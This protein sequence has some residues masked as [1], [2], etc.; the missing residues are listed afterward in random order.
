M[1][2]LQSYRKWFY[3][4]AVYNAVWGAAVVLFPSLIFRTL[5]M[6]LPNYPALMQCIGMLVGVYAIGYWMVGS[7]PERYGP[8][9]YVGLAGKILGPLGYLWA[10]HS[11]ALPFAF[12]WVNVTNDPV[13]LPA[14][15][16]LP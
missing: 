3:A 5:R 1:G 14:L 6:P 10:A 2:D 9:V 4:A 12:G 15:A 11:G 7:N 13:W 16:R 8:F